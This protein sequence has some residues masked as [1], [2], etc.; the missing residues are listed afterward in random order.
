MRKPDAVSPILIFSL[1]ALAACFTSCRSAPQG[2]AVNPLD[3]LD[4]GSSFYLKM[5]EKTDPVLVSRIL[6][7]SVDGLSSEDAG[8]IAERIDVIYTGLERKRNETVIQAA[9]SGNVPR[10]AVSGVFKKNSGWE[11]ASV[12]EKNAA[13]GPVE[14]VYY[15]K[16]STGMQIAFPSNNIVCLGNSVPGMIAGYHSHAFNG[17]T[18]YL[19]ADEVYEWLSGGG[20]QI[21]FYAVKPQSFL[22]VL[23]GANLNLKLAYVK[24]YMVTDGN[25]GDQF[26]MTIEFEFNDER[27]IKAGEGLLSLAFGLT[28]S[29]TQ[30]TTPTH[31]IVSDIRIDKKQLYRLF[32]L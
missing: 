16:K 8:K 30:L 10:T 22:T 1:C 15:T 4:A 25:R 3:I 9:V 11:S 18:S 24:G 29:Q 17:D 23:T 31:L 20:E 6:Q 12:Y 28:D 13:G 2:N 26:I 14:Y 19:V 21:R 32:I 27:M 7:G 5:P